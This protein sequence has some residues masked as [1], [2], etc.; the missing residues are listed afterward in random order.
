[1]SHHASVDDRSDL[2]AQ[3]LGDAVKLPLALA[4][5]HDLAPAAERAPL[6]SRRMP[7]SI[8]SG[9]RAARTRA[10]GAVLGLPGQVVPQ[11]R[12]LLVGVAVL[13]IGHIRPLQVRH[14]GPALQQ[15]GL[16]ILNAPKARAQVPDQLQSSDGSAIALLEPAGPARQWCRAARPRSSCQSSR[17]RTWASAPSCTR[18][19][20]WWVPRR[21]QDPALSPP[22]PAPRRP[23][24]PTQSPRTAPAIVAS[25]FS[26]SG[27]KASQITAANKAQQQASSRLHRAHSQSRKRSWSSSSKNRVWLRLRAVGL[28]HILVGRV[29]F[30]KAPRKARAR[31]SNGPHPGRGADQLPR[32]QVPATQGQPYVA[33]H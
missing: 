19:C 14:E 33:L 6:R 23:G 8:G 2:P 26:K 21:G 22:S 31:P 27:W 25:S 18:R 17:A 24:P 28:P 3:R 16:R 9:Q 30:W 20:R 32:R 7:P 29:F 4:V 13:A 12:G 15:P 10:A 5:L 11:P 1:M